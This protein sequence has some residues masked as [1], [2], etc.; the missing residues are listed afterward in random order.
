SR[1]QKSVKVPPMSTAT[2]RLPISA[3][4]LLREEGA[5]APR[6]NIRAI[7]ACDI[8]AGE[9]KE[10]R[11]RGG[12]D[13]T[14]GQSRDRDRRIAGNRRSDRGPLRGRGRARRGGLRQKPR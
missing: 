9:S 10:C 4:G 2:R 12:N 7:P 5:M 13:E 1:M 3:P 11:V 14:G 8:G 6:R